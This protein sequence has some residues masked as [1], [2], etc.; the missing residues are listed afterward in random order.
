MMTDGVDG[1]CT[2]AMGSVDGVIFL[3]DELAR[4]YVYGEEAYVSADM[5]RKMDVSC[6]LVG[7]VPVIHR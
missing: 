3:A 2:A 7:G 5:L 6:L 1:L 4:V